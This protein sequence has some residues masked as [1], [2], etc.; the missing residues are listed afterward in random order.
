MSCYQKIVINIDGDRR[1]TRAMM[2]AA[3]HATRNGDLWD[4]EFDLLIFELQLNG[5][6]ACVLLYSQPRC[7][8]WWSYTQR[9]GRFVRL[10]TYDTRARARAPG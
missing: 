2:R 6:S 9:K 10:H 5:S 8:K 3:A 7:D 1:A 4:S